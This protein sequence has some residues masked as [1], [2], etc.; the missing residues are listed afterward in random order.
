MIKNNKKLFKGL[1]V[2]SIIGV[3]SLIIGVSFL[4]DNSSFEKINMTEYSIMDT[5]QLSKELNDWV[6]KN[7]NKVGIEYT[8]IDGNTYAIINTGSIGS[9][10]GIVIEEVSKNKTKYKIKYSVNEVKDDEYKENVSLLI[11]F[12]DDLKVV[13]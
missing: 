3:T 1:L 5:K 13:K 2:S 7:K 8:I 6:D 4:K 12:T 11:K 9:G 10:S